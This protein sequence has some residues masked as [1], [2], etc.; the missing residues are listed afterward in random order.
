M[1]AYLFLVFDRRV[2]LTQA[3]ASRQVGLR[4]AA[5]GSPEM[6]VARHEGV[7]WGGFQHMSRRQNG[8]FP[9]SFDLNTKTGSTIS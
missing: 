3:H 6:G 5:R 7:P 9:L 8:W 4:A 2:R 1:L